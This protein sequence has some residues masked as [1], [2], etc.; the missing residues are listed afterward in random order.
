MTARARFSQADLTRAVKAFEKA[1]V[2]VAGAKIHADGT[3]TVLTGEPAA[4]N[5]RYNPLDRVLQ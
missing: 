2:Q 5:D 3:I 1:G 4:A